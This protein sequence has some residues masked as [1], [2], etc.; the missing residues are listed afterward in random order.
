[1]DARE[2][3][4]E[5]IEYADYAQRV[6]GA[7]IDFFLVGIVALILIFGFSV[8]ASRGGP[9]ARI[10]IGLAYAVS[11]FG[12][13]AYYTVCVAEGGQ[14]LGKMSVHTAVRLDGAEDTSLGYIRALG[15]ALV[16]TFLW[17]F[18]IPGL[19]DVLWPFWDRKHQTLHDK[20]VGSVV[21]RV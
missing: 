20:L 15:R 21:I 16:P 2:P 14:T 19:L 5:G 13:T 10:F 4:V 17:L 8:F 3:R 18:L 1:M 11:Y 7:I 12:S 6:K 9:A